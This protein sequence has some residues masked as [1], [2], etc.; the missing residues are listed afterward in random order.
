MQ[1]FIDSLL[2]ADF[3]RAGQMVQNFGNAFGRE[4]YDR[5]VNAILARVHGVVL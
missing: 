3:E 5:L 2:K 4:Y 1:K